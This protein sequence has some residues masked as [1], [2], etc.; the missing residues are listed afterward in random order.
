MSRETRTLGNQTFQDGNLKAAVDGALVP[1]DFTA[2]PLSEADTEWEDFVDAFGTVSLIN[3]VIQA[4]TG[5]SAGTYTNATPMPVSVGGLAA[6]STFD[7]ATMAEMFDGLLYPYQAPA[8]TAFAIAGQT[9]PLE[10]GASIATNRTF[11]WSTSNS[12]NVVANQI[13][14]VD[15]TGGST[16]IA[17]GLANDG[18]E[19]T[20]YPAA[21]IQKTSATTHTFQINGLNTQS[22]SFSATYTVTWQWKKF[23]GESASAGPLTEVNVE[24]L[25]GALSSAFAG[26]YAFNAGGYKYLCYPASFGTATTFKDASTN[27]DVP[28]E[29]SYTVNLTNDYS[30]MTSYRVHRSTNIIGSA[31]NIV[32]S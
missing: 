3:A 1:A 20:S 11:T 26:T 27:L 25:P 16:L 8:F 6:G 24:A 12:S 21:P 30:Q 13:S 32:V 9:T 10:V 15:I 23:Y 31:I 22:G 17:S 19:A 5:G 4:A 2:V 14:L 28:F 7:A 18:T 29:A